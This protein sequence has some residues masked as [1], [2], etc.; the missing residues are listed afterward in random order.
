M[1]IR[2]FSQNTISVKSTESN[3]I[4][5]R[6]KEY[7]EQPLQADNILHQIE[8]EEINATDVRKIEYIT[9]QDPIKK[10]KKENHLKH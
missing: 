5:E 7:F 3:Q 10:L 8:Y 9:K 1:K 4:A 6:W 2:G